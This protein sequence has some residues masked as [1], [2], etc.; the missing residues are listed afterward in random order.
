MTTKYG[1]WTLEELK[2]ELGKRNAKK[3]G[4]K[5]ELVKR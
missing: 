2:T 3:S 5:Q 1:E 4:R